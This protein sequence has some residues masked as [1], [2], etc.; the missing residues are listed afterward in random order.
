MYV[1]DSKPPI[2]IVVP[3]YNQGQFIRATVDSILSQNI[4]GIE[5]L[6]MDGG[7][8][9][10]TVAVLR[11]YGDKIQW[12]SEKDRGQSHAI[13]KGFERARSDILGYINSDDTY[14]PGALASVLEAFRQ[15]PESD[16]VYGDFN[17]IDAAGNILARRRTTNF[18]Y[19][20][21]RFD[22]NFICQPASFWR[23]SVIER[24][25]PIAEDLYYLM[26]YEY[27][28]RAAAAGMRF[29]H[30][31]QNLAN[32]RLHKECKTVS[33]QSEAQQK[34]AAVRAAILAPYSFHVHPAVLDRALHLALKAA[35]RLK[36]M[37]RYW[38]ENGELK[39]LQS[40]RELIARV[41]AE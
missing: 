39:F 23:R 21:L 35:I 31:R 17:Y 29:F 9:D 22:H 11:S 1:A 6:V 4:E 16:F 13:N 24:I 5:I 33:G 30:V 19:D 25:G 15:H 26:D 12:V 20:I 40:S 3:S 8:K 27:Y 18:D 32:L 34:Y 37:G 36:K 2:S 10:E 38:I 41:Q 14:Q 28:L 7:S